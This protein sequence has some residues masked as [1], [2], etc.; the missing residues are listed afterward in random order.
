MWLRMRKL[1]VNLD[2]MLEHVMIVEKIVLRCVGKALLDNARSEVRMLNMTKSYDEKKVL[3]HNC[4]VYDCGTL[5]NVPLRSLILLPAIS[6][7]RDLMDF[8]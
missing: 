7:R 4:T 2:A 6:I 5:H 1:V 8:R 3:S